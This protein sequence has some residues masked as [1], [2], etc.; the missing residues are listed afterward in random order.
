MKTPFYY[1]D[2]NLLHDT[3]DALSSAVEGSPFHVHYA[4]KA[5]AEHRIL[6]I[7]KEYGLGAD[8]VSGNEIKRALEIGFDADSIV[9]AG[10]GKTDEELH[11]AIKN[12]IHSINCESVEELE[13]IN[14]IAAENNS[15]ARIAFRLN[16]NIDAHTHHHITTGLNENKFGIPL[17]NLGAALDELDKYE[18]LKLCGI[19]FHIGSQILNLNPYAKLCMEANDIQAYL[20]SRNIHLDHLNMGGGLGVDY[21]NP[22]NQIIPNFEEYFKIFKRFL[23]PLPNQSIHFE[24]GRS[25]VAQMGSLISKVLYVKKGHESNFAIIDAG[26]TDLIRPALYN[27]FHKIENLRSSDETQSYKVV[28]PICESTDSFGEVQLPKT[29]RGDLLQIRSA[30]AYGQVLSS[31]YNLRDDASAVYSDELSIQ[32]LKSSCQ[33]KDHSLTNNIPNVAPSSIHAA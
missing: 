6:K 15:R 14:Q 8:C 31:N 12:G 17:S 3:L 29:N 26:M 2:L 18:H 21:H 7:I 23:K 32:D 9:L 11:L 4:I 19:H 33:S 13:V 24:L 30:G 20:Q 27:S 22:D 28:G 16:P 1:Y 25:I 5:N 10:V